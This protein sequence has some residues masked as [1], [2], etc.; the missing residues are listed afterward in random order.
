MLFRL[1]GGRV[2]ARLGHLTFLALTT[3]GRKSGRRR[4]TMLSYTRDGD[5]L[6]I[7]G[8]RGGSPRDPDWWRNLEAHP[9]AE[10]QVGPSTLRVRA[11]EAEGAERERL[12]AAAVA[13]DR[14]YATYRRRTKRRIP[15]VVLEPT[16]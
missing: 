9:E 7:I 11:S 3:V 8:S 15:V 13:S 4:T 6:V 14:R 12:W 16:S 5:R 1:T 2:G 10:V